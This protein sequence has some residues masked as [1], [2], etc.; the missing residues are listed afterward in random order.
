MLEGLAVNIAIVHIVDAC[1]WNYMLYLVC[2]N[3]QHKQVILLHGPFYQNS[4]SF[5]L[6]WH[7]YAV[8]NQK[9]FNINYK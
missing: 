1:N 7:L 8:V 6:G 4:Y 2:D 3:M 9:A 5:L